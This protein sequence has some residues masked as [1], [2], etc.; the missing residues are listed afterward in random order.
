MTL[1]FHKLFTRYPIKSRRF[2]ELLP[3]L[4]SW[5]VILS[6]IWG[7]LFAPALLAYFILFFDI[8]WFYKSYS[9]VI[10]AHRGAN[11]IRRAE[12]ENWL[13]KAE[14]LPNYDKINHVLIVLSYKESL[15]KI[16]LTVDNLTRQTLPLK[17]LH[18]VLAMEEREAEAPEKANE[19]MKEFKNSFGSI[20]ATYHTDAPGE[21]KGKSSNE[22]FA[23]KAAYQKLFVEGN[24]DIDYA[25]VSSVDVDSIFD[26][27]FFACLTYKFLTD[28]KRYHKFWQSAGVF[29]SNIWLVPAPV[30]ILSFFG[31]LWRT[32]M[33]VQGDKLITQST[34]SLSFKML[35]D[36]GFWDADVIPEDYRIFFKAFFKLKGQVWT[37]PIFLKT[38][39][40]AAY[41]NG[42]INSL[43]NKYHQERRWSWGVSD[44]PLFITWWFTVPE[45]PFVR[46][47][48]VVY[49][50][51]LDHFL[52][53]V[54]WFIV[55]VA[56]NIMPF[57]N[58]AFSRTALGYSLPRLAGLILTSTIIALIAM[59]FIDYKNRPENVSLP[60]R[61]KIF[62]PFEF[63]LMPIVG[64]FLS[65]LPALISHTQLMFGKRMEYK[66]TEKA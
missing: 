31:S 17:K 47:T 1:F 15:S 29:Y 53:P 30:R 56:A 7:S 4:A 37:E 44:D 60:L 49:T 6:P 63:I 9:L 28:A 48:I 52:W 27:Q 33:L 58:P 20:F 32:S 18:V 40:D 24:L 10:N 57:I 22:A 8:Y 62:F 65:A 66:V 54:N 43:K 12:K 16:R 25:T 51:L 61:R 5:T 45:I 3:G 14:K 21:V 42:Y 39:M 19:L 26:K 13:E 2:L 23:G 41:S 34:Y 55:T 36:I 64:F 11:R 38:Y 35:R 59:M 50:V 46:K